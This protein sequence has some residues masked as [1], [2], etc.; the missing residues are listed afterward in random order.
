MSK[1]KYETTERSYF[2]IM[3]KLTVFKKRLY[4]FIS[5]GSG[6]KNRR[7]QNKNVKKNEIGHRGGVI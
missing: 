7:T 5:A 2:M 6:V 4:R 3:M 1:I